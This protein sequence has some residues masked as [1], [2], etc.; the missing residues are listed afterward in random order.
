MRTRRPARQ[1]PRR[2]APQA[3][4]LPGDVTVM[5]MFCYIDPGASLRG[6]LF[7]SLT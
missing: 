7:Q 5:N 3:L 1:A 6:A 2:R 4:D